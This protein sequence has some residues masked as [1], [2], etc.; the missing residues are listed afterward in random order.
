MVIRLPIWHELFPSNFYYKTMAALWLFHM[1]EKI[2]GHEIYDSFKMSTASNAFFNNTKL[3]IP[4]VVYE[5]TCKFSY[6]QM[7]SECAVRLD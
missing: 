3:P 5:F 4:R 2:A 1:Q 6:E 7:K